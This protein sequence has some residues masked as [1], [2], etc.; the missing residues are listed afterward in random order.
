[1]WVAGVAWGA[2]L[3][4]G[5]DLGPQLVAEGGDQ[6]GGG[7]DGGVLHLLVLVLPRKP[8]RHR[9][10]HRPYQRLH[11][12]GTSVGT[13]SICAVHG[14]TRAELAKLANEVIMSSTCNFFECL[15]G[16]LAGVPRSWRHPSSKTRR[17]HE[18]REIASG[19]GQGTLSFVGTALMGSGRM[20]WIICSVTRSAS[21][22]T[23]T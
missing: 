11:G 1:M 15:Q 21:A 18:S 16:F 4:Q 3:K 23:C 19:A 2:C 17:E 5:R 22:D 9:A 10:V 12:H 14:G 7:G 6:R 13:R 8:R 20:M